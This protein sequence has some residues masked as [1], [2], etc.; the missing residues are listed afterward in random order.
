[1]TWV[2]V[3]RGDGGHP[4]PPEINVLITS[5]ACAISKGRALLDGYS[6]TPQSVEVE[7]VYRTGLRLG[8]LLQVHDLSQGL[9][10]KAKLVGINHRVVRGAVSTILDLE[11]PTT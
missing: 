4:A 7:A 3:K 2:V 6:S 11:K 5:D 8:Q 10:W 9:Q 1:M